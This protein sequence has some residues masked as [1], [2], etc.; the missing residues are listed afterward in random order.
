VDDEVG[1]VLDQR[2]RDAKQLIISELFAPDRAI[3]YNGV[4]VTTR[5]DVVT[6]Q[7]QFSLLRKIQE[8]TVHRDLGAKKNV[9]YITISM[10]I[11]T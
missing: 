1:L 11:F 10:S 3:L 7:N 4:F 5:Y 6:R 9:L 2:H 8:S